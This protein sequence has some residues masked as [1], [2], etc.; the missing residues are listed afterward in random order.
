MRAVLLLAI[1]LL[2]AAT[3]SL[4]QQKLP[5]SNSDEVKGIWNRDVYQIETGTLAHEVKAN[6]FFISRD[7]KIENFWTSKTPELLEHFKKQPESKIKLGIF[8]Q[9]NSYAIPATPEEMQWMTESMWELYNNPAW[10]KSESDL[11]DE[12][13]T[14]CQKEKI[15]LYVNMSR[16]LQG[17]WKMLNR[18]SNDSSTPN[19]KLT[20]TNIRKKP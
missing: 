9:S 12:L 3:C 18:P 15:T 13:R 1:S 2:L 11:I 4:A 14:A 17:K 16:N 7:P 6:W 20:N 19:T 5:D 10:R 8:I